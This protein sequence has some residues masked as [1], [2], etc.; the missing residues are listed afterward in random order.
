MVLGKRECPG[1]QRIPKFSSPETP[2]LG[3]SLSRVEDLI[4]QKI[5]HILILPWEG[6][7]ASADK[8][9]QKPGACQRGGGGKGLKSLETKAVFQ[10][11]SLC[12]RQNEAQTQA[13]S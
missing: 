2:T 8:E 4:A 5:L 3:F 13:I 10:I 1:T 9:R 7:R 6:I 11:S 12:Q